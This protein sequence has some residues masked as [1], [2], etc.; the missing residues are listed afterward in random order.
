MT[1]PDN[2]ARKGISWPRAALR[3]G[4]VGLLL[5]LGANAAYVMIGPNFHAVVPGQVY[6]C[7]QPSGDELERL[8]RRYGVRTVINL[9][10][11]CPPLPWYLDECRAT[12]RCNVAQEDVTLSA[13]RLPS[14]HEVRRLVDV[15]DRSEY[16]VLIHCRR[17]ADRTGLAAVAALLLRSDIPLAQA[18]RQLSLSYGHVAVGKAAYL[19][20]FFDFYEEWLDRQGLEHSPAVFRRW[21]RRE[22]CPG[23]CRCE[24]ELL[25]PLEA[26]PP[27]RPFAVRVRA[28]NTS[29]RTW[30]LR[31]GTAAGVH[32]S[33]VVYNHHQHKAASGEGGLF[34]AEVPP[35]R[36]IDLTLALPALKPGRYRLLVDMTDGQHCW[37]LQTG[38]EPLEQEFVV[39]E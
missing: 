22:Y 13:G 7:A 19:N 17:G 15:L 2:G 34:E 27:G 11:C 28:R 9:R 18:R 31:R 3:G 36:S 4:A 23:V 39:R 26:V 38:S 6:R 1:E 29:F 30:R 21:A 16:P 20:Q 33:Y 24:L 32:A 10:G 12:H 8:I 37:F 35:G 25:E 14:I 5:A